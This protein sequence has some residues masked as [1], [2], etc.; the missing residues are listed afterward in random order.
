MLE[1]IFTKRVVGGIY[2]VDE[3]VRLQLDD[4]K[5]PTVFK[6]H[7]FEYTPETLEDNWNRRDGSIDRGTWSELG[8]FKSLADAKDFLETGPQPTRA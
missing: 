1:P 7:F 3:I 4:Y 5:D 6:V 8:T 2:A